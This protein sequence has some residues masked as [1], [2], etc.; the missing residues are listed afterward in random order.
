M[1]LYKNNPYL[2]VFETHDTFFDAAHDQALDGA[3]VDDDTLLA[4]LAGGEL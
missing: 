1:P 4:F 3:F 2:C